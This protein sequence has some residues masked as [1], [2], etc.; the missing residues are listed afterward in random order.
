MVHLGFQNRNDMAYHGKSLLHND[1][2]II[3]NGQLRLNNGYYISNSRNGI[4]EFGR[5][6]FANNNFT[7]ICNNRI[8]IGDECRFAFGVRMMTTDTHFSI[9]INSY[10][11]NTNSHPIVLGKNNWITSDVKIMKG[12]VTPD[13]TIVTAN[14]FLNKD[15]SKSI[16]PNC[17]L[18]G[19]P[20]KLIKEGQRRIFSQKNE[21]MLR[22]YFEEN[23]NEKMRIIS[24]DIDLDE[25]CKI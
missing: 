25:F 17:I 20:A 3:V 1:G 4:I 9:D 21:D 6:I 13:W 23:P 5:T 16:G 11:I 15:Y 18:G 12:T 2:L 19:Q 10:I 8:I 22:E 14:S 24:H 7:V